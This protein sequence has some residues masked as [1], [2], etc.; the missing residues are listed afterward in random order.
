MKK[1]AWTELIIELSNK[2]VTV[3]TQIHPEWAKKVLSA[4]V[5]YF[6]H[7][8]YFNSMKEDGARDIEPS[9][10]Y[11]YVATPEYDKVTD[12]HYIDLPVKMNKMI[13]DRQLQFVGPKKGMHNA[14]VQMKG[15]SDEKT[16]T[17]TLLA[18]TN[19]VFFRAEGAGKV[20]FRNLEGGVCEVLM[21]YVPDID[22][23]SDTDEVPVPSE[24]EADVIKIAREFITGKRQIPDD[25]LADNN[26]EDK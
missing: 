3:E 8:R 12:R 2:V 17:P 16:L 4:S 1:A 21:L 9:L 23:L 7:A 25:K 14:Y 22:D 13:K 20:V 26:E 6:L 19:Q 11:R 18:L 15:I 5:N 10:L 24:F